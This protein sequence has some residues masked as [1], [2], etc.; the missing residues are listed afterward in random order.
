VG[1]VEMVPLAAARSAGPANGG[2]PAPNLA[3][4]R[5]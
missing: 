3:E 2:R 5:R 4:A 1:S